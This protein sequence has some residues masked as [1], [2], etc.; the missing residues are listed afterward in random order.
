M[1][2]VAANISVVLAPSLLSTVRAFERFTDAVN[3]CNCDPDGELAG[4]W[5]RCI[6]D[7]FEGVQ[8]VA[9]PPSW[10]ERN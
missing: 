4:A 7:V 6:K 3:R 2:E 10:A 8:V 1:N 5:R 9:A